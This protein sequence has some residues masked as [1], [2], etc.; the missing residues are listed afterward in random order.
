MAKRQ[1]GAP[2]ADQQIRRGATY[3]DT[4]P[5]SVRFLAEM[6]TASSGFVLL[7]MAG[8][9]WFVPAVLGVTVPLSLLLSLWVLTRRAVLPFHLP[10]YSG[11]IDEH[12]LDPA[13]RKPRKANG[14]VYLGTD[15]QSGQQLWLSSDAARQ[16]AAMPGT[17]GAG[18]TTS[19]ISL[20]ANPLAH[21]SGFILVDG[22]GDNTVHGDV[23]ALARR[24]GLDDQVYNLNFLTASS[25][26]ESNSFNPFATGN[27]DA[28]RE[29]L[30]SQLGEPASNDANGVFRDR[31]V[32]LIGTLT[33]AL[34][35]M[36]DV[37]GLA[38]NIETIRFATEL[39][40][41]ASLARHRLFLVRVPG[42]N[43]PE[44]IEVRDIP[45]DILYPLQAYLGELP[46]YDIGLE[47]N[48]QKENKPSE[49]HGYATMYF[50][51]V[52][53]Q[54]GVSLGHIFKVE[55]GDIDMRDIVLNRR[56]LV[57][58]LPA[59]ENSSD[60]LAGLGKIIVASVRGVMAQLLGARL[61]GPANE[62]FKLKAGS[63]DAPFQI[64]FDEL[65]AYVTDGMDRM[66]AMG[67]GL[68][69]MF[70]L[71]FQDL[72]GLTTRIGDKA[73]TLLGN[74]NLTHAMRLQDA[75][76][77]REWI[78]K[79]ADR[80]EVTQATHYEGN[81]AGSYREGRG[82]EVREVARIPWAD[83][84]S[85]I[86]GEAITLYGGR[87]V[88]SKTF[89]AAL[90]G[91]A[92]EVRL[93]APIMLASRRHAES[94]SPDDET[95]AVL[96]TIENG[97]FRIEM[98]TP[99]VE[100]A[101][102]KLVAGIGTLA[103]TDRNFQQTFTDVALSL[104]GV[105]VDPIP[106]DGATAIDFPKPR[107]EEPVTPFD[108]MLRNGARQPQRGFARTPDPN[109]PLDGSLLSALDMIERLIDPRPGVARRK[110]LLLM[111]V[112]DELNRRIV[113]SEKAFVSPLS[114]DELIERL[115]ALQEALA[116]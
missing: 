28:I 107:P 97:S 21:G 8:A 84:Q 10:R 71:G 116:A 64:F 103:P 91:R 2:T 74:A 92:G 50:S 32:N 75:M 76:R 82:A 14:I 34:V 79:Q 12:D 11:L 98:P 95:R 86:E 115:E 83:L 110:A 25:V 38:I 31:A 48:Q 17:T 51:R 69:C 1:I 27:A 36:R 62:I 70:W 3:R 19:A 88:H 18:K 39:R 6:R 61:N 60:T 81:S 44:K 65:A 89:Y 16:H 80:V 105:S 108:V 90:N 24:F 15:A 5:L 30:V 57:V 43:Q 9:T 35:W 77:T 56:I 63:G 7:V 55:T 52:F 26:R 100:P 96:E 23:L 106:A 45:D 40:W 20:L 102:A 109:Q 72:P 49:Q 87:V 73:F 59:L 114:D 58:T 104:V 33:P 101:L 29:M 94:G 66:L 22:K 93:S 112:R 37:H 4:R 67:R 111:G 99:V 13:T 85:L 54:F 78:E 53:T 68:N 41:I 42:S 47:W 46:G 113:A